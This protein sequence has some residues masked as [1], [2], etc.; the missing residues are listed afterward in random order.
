MNFDEELH[1]GFLLTRLPREHEW[2]HGHLVRSNL[3]YDCELLGRRTTMLFVVQKFGVGASCQSKQ[4]LLT[5]DGEGVEDGGIRYTGDW[6]ETTGT[7]QQK[8]EALGV[9]Q[10]IVPLL[11]NDC[12]FQ[13]AVGFIV[14]HQDYETVADL[15]QM[16]RFEVP[17]FRSEWPYSR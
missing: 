4:F 15:E 12:Q 6:G 16:A 14:R 11:Y 17:P 3:A 9:R 8:A 10:V 1:Y 2:W 5:L 13:R 7:E